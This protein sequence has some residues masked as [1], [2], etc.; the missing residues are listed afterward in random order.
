MNGCLDIS[1][2]KINPESN[3]IEIT[4]GKKH[5]NTKTQIWLEYGEVYKDE[6]TNRIG[7]CHDTEL[8]CGGD[9]FEEAIIKLANNMKN[10]KHYRDMETNNVNNI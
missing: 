6:N 8:D 10:S 2:V 5:L 9:T 4:E 7:F 3:E 1:V